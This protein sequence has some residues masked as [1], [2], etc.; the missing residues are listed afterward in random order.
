M[1]QRVQIIGILISGGN[2]QNPRAQYVRE[3]MND[4][5]RIAVIGNVCGQPI[6]NS[7]AS[8]GLSQ[9]KHTGIRRDRAAIKRGGDF[10]G[11]N[12]RK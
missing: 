12:G 4:A 7:K 3:G 2:R 9:E 6:D 1:A 5:C 10:L 11:L 8:L